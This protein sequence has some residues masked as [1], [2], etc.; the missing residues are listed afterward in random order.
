MSFCFSTEYSSIDLLALV[1]EYYFP[2]PKLHYKCSWFSFIDWQQQTFAK[3]TIILA[4]VHFLVA[5]FQP[6]IILLN[7]VSTMNIE[8]GYLPAIFS[9]LPL[10]VLI[11]IFSL[12]NKLLGHGTSWVSVLA[13]CL[14]YA[15]FHIVVCLGL[16]KL[17]LPHTTGHSEP[18]P[19][20]CSCFANTQL[21]TWLIHTIANAP[22]SSR[23]REGGR[24][25]KGEGES[26]LTF[27]PHFDHWPVHLHEVLR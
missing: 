13:L 25:V 18:A 4:N 14:L 7:R 15:L 12:M 1:H 3:K 2:Q 21:R 16:A 5:V 20:R 6:I 17:H 27:L 22:A 19:T 24:R 8:Q 11:S 9:P 26:S 10:P 23:G